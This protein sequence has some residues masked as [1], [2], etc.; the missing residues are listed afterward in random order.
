MLTLT[1]LC[2]LGAFITAVMSLAGKC[3]PSVAVLLLIVIEALCV[4]P[5]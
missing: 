3:H 2:L 4:I 1:L 5:K